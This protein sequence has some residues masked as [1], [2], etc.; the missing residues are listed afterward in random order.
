MLDRAA[1]A[2]SKMLAEGCDTLRACALDLEQA[3]AVGM[4]AWDR[5][6]FHGLAAKRV[7]HIEALSVGKGDAVAKVADMIDGETLNHGARR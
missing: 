6:N 7:R 3:P 1:A 5:G 4:L 2:G